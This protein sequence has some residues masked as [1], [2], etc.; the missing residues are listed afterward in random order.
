MKRTIKRKLTYFVYGLAIA[1][2]S[3][4]VSAVN[5]SDSSDPVKY[6]QETLDMSSTTSGISAN[7]GSTY[8]DL[9]D[10]ASNDLDVK[11]DLGLAASAVNIGDDIYFRLDLEGAVFSSAVPPNNLFITTLGTTDFLAQGG[12]AG[13]SFA[14]LRMTPT[15]TNLGNELFTFSMPGLAVLLDEPVSVRFASYLSL[16]EAINEVN[17][18]ASV[19]GAYIELVDGVSI[20]DNPLPQQID[21]DGGSINYVV[22]EGST[23][24][25]G[26][27][28]S[29]GSI[30]VKSIN[31]LSSAT[32]YDQSGSVHKL[33]DSVTGSSNISISGDFQNGVYY[34]DTNASCP[35]SD[36]P[37]NSAASGAL[38][39][40]G[41]I[42]STT[43]G[44]LESNPWLCHVAD[45]VDFIT[46]SSYE[47]TI[48]YTAAVGSLQRENG[49]SSFG[50][51]SL[52]T[53]SNP[54][55]ECTFGT[56][57][58]PGQSSLI[59]SKTVHFANPGSNQ[60]QQSFIRLSN[61]SGSPVD[62]EVY[63]TDDS[64]QLSR[65]GPVLLSLD[66]STSIQLT[67]QDLEDGSIAKGLINS[68]CDGYGKWRLEIRSSEDIDVMSLIRT[69]DGFL[70]GMSAIAPVQGEARVA[71]FVNPASNASQQSFIRV[72]NLSETE[73]S[74]TISGIDDSG[75]QSASVVIL[76]LQPGE[77]KQ[78]TS[79]DIENGN[80][81]KGLEGLL[82]DGAGKWRLNVSS[83]SEI[84]VMSLIRSS[85]GFLTNLSSVAPEVDSKHSVYLV[86][87]ASEDQ[88]QSF[89]RVT[90][91]T[92]QVGMVTISATD[93]TGAGSP[94]GDVMFS[95]VAQE[96]KQM[97]IQDLESGSSEKGLLGALG[98]GEGS[99]RLEVVAD[100]EIKVMSLV[101]T[102]D[103]FLTN[104]SDVTP[105]ANSV[106]QV[107]FFNPA[108]NQNQ[109]SVLRIVN[110]SAQTA[111]VT[112][113]GIDDAGAPAPGGDVTF[114]LLAGSTKILSSQDLESGNGPLG[115]VG[116]LGDG[117][118]K[119]RLEV[120]SSVELQ[121]QS[122]LETPN[123]FITNLSSPVAN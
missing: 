109:L 87:P 39:S 90:N 89:V 111:A 47:V 30:E 11:G 71:Y 92:D 24:L 2:A 62:I 59:S 103:G 80:S 3:V 25:S 78:V 19:S 7:A 102:A 66:G 49:Q 74:V 42:R 36:S 50:A 56:P 14:I 122:I 108:S 107:V 118:G 77:S 83:A 95:L 48:E 34:L 121:V 15:V 116:S 85:D 76:E 9:V 98:D 58:P 55:D 37:P 112:I 67:A 41:D 68:L 13:E 32:V 88:Q 52:A 113:S 18:L 57:S 23:N 65:K 100:L 94:G 46:P 26:S 51:V 70:T 114:N 93:E 10:T 27:V 61:L 35:L 1:L 84:S 6:A 97:T 81:L 104:V 5:I 110:E 105:V 43:L 123:G 79:Q 91:T 20:V 82:G 21:V 28:A 22:N 115:L 119:W 106:N 64:G 31:E 54:E 101:R 17:A 44:V 8:F 86:N 4:T 29:L 12:Q 53:P 120:S 38:L 75:V 16:G 73:A 72:S 45:G 40:T 99:W 33:D 117:S 60:N 63:G 69:P 96:S